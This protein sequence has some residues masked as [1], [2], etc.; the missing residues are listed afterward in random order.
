L[1]LVRSRRRSNCKFKKC[2]D[3]PQ[4]SVPLTQVKGAGVSDREAIDLINRLDL[5]TL[6]QALDTFE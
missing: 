5:G 2:Y 6:A 3:M 4:E 1:K